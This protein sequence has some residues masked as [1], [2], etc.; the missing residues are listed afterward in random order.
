MVMSAVELDVEQK[1]LVKER[2]RAI[3]LRIHTKSYITSIWDNPVRL[4][5]EIDRYEDLLNKG[6]I[7]DSNI[8]SS[9]IHA[10]EPQGT[11]R[12][13]TRL[14]QNN[15]KET[16]QK[17]T[18]TQS[19]SGSVIRQKSD[20]IRGRSSDSMESS[21][22]VRD[23]G[24]GERLKP[25][26]TGRIDTSIPKDIILDS[27][28]DINHK[29]GAAA[30]FDANLEAIRTLKHIEAEDR[31]A[32]PKEQA[33]LAKYSGFGDSA[34]ND[35]FSNYRYRNNE[36][37]EKRGTE[38][39][40]ITTEKEYKDIERSRLNAFYTTPEVINTT[41]DTL[42][43]LGA[44]KIARPHV[45]E[46][47]AGS[48]RFLGYQP[49]DWAA[50]SERSA[51]ELDELT[52]RMV[53]QMYPETAT[54]VMGYQKAPI[55][56]N[57][58]DI[59]ISNV[60]FGNY[61]VNDPEFTKKDKYLT[62]S[63]HNYFFA[64]TLR[65]LRPGGV[66]AF[67]TS[68]YT[69]DAQGATRI[70]E[71]LS[72]KADL[73]GAI[74]LPHNAFPDTEVV[75]D[76]VFM[77]KR[78]PNEA[79]K[80]TSWVNTVDVELKDQYN[81]VMTE[82]VNQYFVDNPDNVL[83]K[84]EI[85]YGGGMYSRYQYSVAPT[86]GDL[87]NKLKQAVKRLPE[88]IITDANL[89]DNRDKRTRAT[90]MP[91][92][93][94]AFEGSRVIG[95]DGKIYVKRKG[96][97]VDAEL[98]PQ[99]QAQVRDML[100][101]RDAA[102]KVLQIQVDSGDDD[103][104]QQAQQLLNSHYNKYT[105]DYGPLHSIKNKKL[106]KGDPDGPFLLALEKTNLPDLPEKKLSKLSKLSKKQVDEIKMPIF[107]GRT[108]HGKA[109][110]V[111][112]SDTDAAI[113]SFNE[114]GNLDF[115]RIGE[116][117]GKSAKEARKSLAEKQAIFKNPV[118]GW[119]MADEYLSGDVREKLRIAK[120]KASV[121]KEYEV[122]V[123]ALKAVQPKELEP[124]QIS[125]RLGANWIPDTTVNEFVEHLLNPY[126]GSWKH[127]DKPHFV[128][129]PATGEWVNEKKIEGNHTVLSEEWGTPRM[130][131]PEIIKRLLNGKN[132]VVNDRDPDGKA[133]R[134]DKETAAA[135]EKA[136]AVQNEFKRWVWDDPDRA[137]NLSNIYNTTFNGYRP[138][139]FNGKHQDLPGMTEEW[140]RKLHP[141]IK[142]AIWRVVQ[143]RTALF[144]HEVGFGKTAAM[145]GS[146]M[147]LKRLGIANKPM[148][149]VPKAVH[150]QFQKEFK[151]IY[152]YA[153]ILFPEEGDFSKDN[154]NEFV[155]RVAT[156]DWDA[157]L[158]SESQFRRLPVK[159]ET[160]AKFLREEVNILRDALDQEKAANGSK[161]K[162]HKDI[163]KTLARAEERLESAQSQ[164]GKLTDDTMYF[165]DMGV[166]QLFV[167][168][169]DMFK[170]LQFTTRMGRIKGLPN[171]KSD[172]AWDMYQKIRYLKENGDHGVVFATGT[173][174]ANTIAEMYT[175]MRYLQKPM[176]E[177]KGLEHFDS[178][179]K[180][181]GETTEALEQTPT[182]DY[183]MTQRFA[184]FNNMPEL[185]A[186]WQNVAD[187]KVAEE[188]PGV[189][190]LR[191]RLVDDEGKEKRTVVSIPM[192]DE[193]RAY[194][195]E[196]ADRAD[197]LPITDPR[198]D[199]ML[200]IA[201]DA[202]MASLDMRM[203]DS[204]AP[205]NPNGKIATVS[206]N[207]ARIYKD[208]DEDKGTQLI[209]LDLGTPKAKDKADADDK[210]PDETEVETKV[211]R[212]VYGK[213]KDNLTKTGIPSNEIAFIHDAKTDKA[214]KQL[215][216]K[217]N[218][219]ELRVI[220]G[221]T[222]KLGTGVNVQQ[223]AAALHHI[224]APWRPRDIEQRE[225][226]IIRQGNKVYGPKME[227]GEIVDPGK[228]VKIFTYV[229]EGSFDAYMWQAIESKSK[230][231]KAIMRRDNP[232]REISDVD[233]FTMSAGEAKAIATGN[234]DVMNAMELENEIKK[235]QMVQASHTDSKFRAQHQLQQLPK[236][237]ETTTKKI[238]KLEKDAENVKA[239]KDKDFSIVIG[240]KD[241][242]ERPEAGKTLR[243]VVSNIPVTDGP[244]TIG[245]Y[246]G[247]TITA[248][249]SGETTGYLIA[250]HNSDS[251]MDYA[252]KAIPYDDLSDTGVLK[253]IDNKINSVPDILDDARKELAQDEKSLKTYQKQAVAT[254]AYS[255]RLK[256]LQQEKNRLERKLKWKTG[257]KEVEG[258]SQEYLALKGEDSPE[259]KGKTYRYGERSDKLSSIDRVPTDL[260][261]LSDEV[262]TDIEE[263]IIYAAI[264][265]KRSDDVIADDM[266]SNEPI[267]ITK[268]DWEPS[269]NDLK[270]WDTTHIKDHQEAFGEV[271]DKVKSTLDKSFKDEQVEGRVKTLPSI[272]KKLKKKNIDNGP[273]THNN[274][275]D[276]AG[277]RVTFDNLDD[278]KAG[279][280]AIKGKYKIKEDEDYI[281]KPKNGYRS[282]HLTI[283]QDGKPLE[284]QFRTPNMTKWA[285]WTH[286]TLYDHTDVIKKKVGANG[287]KELMNYAQA[288]SDYYAAKDEGKNPDM[289]EIPKVADKVGGGM[290]K[291]IRF[292]KPQKAAYSA[293]IDKGAKQTAIPKQNSGLQILEASKDYPLPATKVIKPNKMIIVSEVTADKPKGNISVSTTQKETK[294][295]PKIT[296]TRADINKVQAARTERA[297]KLDAARTNKKVRP[298][299]D[300]GP[301]LN[302][303]ERYD[304]A[305]VDTPKRNG[306]HAGLLQI[307]GNAGTIIKRG[308]ARGRARKSRS[309]IGMKTIGRGRR[310]R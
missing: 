93:I 273:F 75:T 227:N 72:E 198:E 275:E 127:R 182:G 17:N 251:G 112:D 269:Q 154:R 86:E 153:N 41:W 16:R 189:R 162:S 284:V 247:Y 170:N 113:V 171:T 191:P 183:R 4:K 246:K 145:V 287:F 63:I 303:P 156:G 129:V 29:A 102:R 100:K 308:S 222:N 237:I 62:R 128:Y 306:K 116:L 283:E 68:R 60:P 253:R 125:V 118:G 88:N 49:A 34:F 305:G 270:G 221:S 254:F 243:D 165:E 196:L 180:M 85:K 46:P 73:L 259:D 45:L 83:G 232:P 214:R 260:P 279:V 178:W 30:R 257:D 58:I 37:W 157:V 6:V 297:R 146:G 11:D 95:E 229:T 65:K 92:G 163:Q 241:Y 155:S 199:N 248:E 235:L 203:V 230:A 20:R 158:L 302:H 77:R 87:G 28:T 264:R 194:M 7:N 280:K 293:T 119:E 169:A 289:P 271:Y 106:M 105:L 121:K 79:A 26:T 225:G 151:E 298:I 99:E 109:D 81:D 177:A 134:N 18:V 115:D 140:N 21:N 181:F 310:R 201:S 137:V 130:G 139:T 290:E 117:L 147:E 299:N 175:M 205:A 126:R 161:S 292:P 295:R 144:A 103:D 135:M 44:D 195:V 104:L 288:M 31:Q 285:D 219:G 71:H 210:E 33:I 250:I 23:T 296:V 206:K 200:K 138:R 173:P 159:P 207:V 217:V 164:V 244:K 236:T 263:N 78:A 220:I 47:S 97:L 5:Q 208:T 231:I 255:D 258:P 39:K 167:D 278:L 213:L 131:A 120:A 266:Q 80:D 226:R 84:P 48:G 228:G 40:E 256:I 8:Q 1:N 286:N 96:T 281:T 141:H 136:K 10:T 32:T 262:D 204:D 202:R 304:L 209:F 14:R 54:Y 22:P 55:A 242:D 53:K 35:A 142:D 307:H 27:S 150:K 215:Y 267:V 166:D 291:Q 190:K 240:N 74:R 272:V 252:L 294:G 64:K 249:N 89:S 111:I 211:L 238:N 197:K 67:V 261:A 143:D 123:K 239:H 245:K 152:P 187:I 24:N 176:L 38:L 98:S 274:M 216:K 218:S 148:Y 223:R 82:K 265:D 133:I 76:I 56:D 309:V 277:L 3:E 192:S 66:M 186:M 168:E 9:G 43:K 132:V 114:T 282:Y 212:N 124:S 172:R 19:R 51:V 2:T 193:L 110:R 12:T 52:G 90:S 233:S 276:I 179:A 224:D 13:S 188:V 122:N 61:G 42:R 15:G 36:A 108:I 101:I 57:S 185:S 174:V 70:R 107:N 25:L 234:P 69:M 160:E 184:K 301:W 94:N 149:V 268:R 91:S 300:A 59:A 50:R